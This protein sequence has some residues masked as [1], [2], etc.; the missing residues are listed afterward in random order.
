MTNAELQARKDAATPRGLSITSD[1]FAARAEN[2]ELWDVE[3]RRFID[4]ASGIAVNNVGHRHSQVVAAAHAQLDRVMHTSYQTVPYAGYVELAEEMNARAPGAFRKKTAFFTTGVEAV[5]NAV[6]I[7][8]FATGRSGVIA[9][10]GAFHG[11]TLL[12]MALTGKSVPYKAGFG[13]LPPEVF[14][15]PFPDALRG[16]S[17]RD[18]LRGIEHILKSEID[19]Q[20]VAAIVFEPVQGEGGFNPAPAELVRGLAALRDQHGI[21]LVADEIQTGFARTGALFAMEHHGVAADI[22]AFAKSL[23]GGLPLSGVTGRAE[24]MDAVPPGGLGSTYA[25][26]PVAIAAAHAVLEV[27]DSERLV[28]RAQ[29]LGRQLQERLT[30]LAAATPQLRDVRGLG[31]MVAA[32]FCVPGGTTPDA[33]FAK[34]VVDA[35]RARGLILL[36]CGVYSNAIRFLYP[37]TIP[38]AVFAE[39][40][41]ILEAALADAASVPSEAVAA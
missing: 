10:S 31:S 30:R 19:P 4:F 35:A 26:N 18:A 15:A 13:P 41:D 1:F 24:I 33:A 25:G 38:P 32:E 9:F 37:L 8:R 36:T 23:A 28:E 39:G 12:G 40:L 16:V 27:I 34:R 20:R 5:E 11:R 22:M 7:A 29:A 6:K 2:A 17:A 21:L 3:G 14:H